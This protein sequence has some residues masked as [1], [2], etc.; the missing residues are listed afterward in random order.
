MKKMIFIAFVLALL[1]IPALVIAQPPVPP[2]DATVADLLAGNPKN[3]ITDIGDVYVWDDAGNIY[4][5]YDVTE[6]GWVL[7]S[8]HLHIQA[9]D[10]DGNPFNGNKPDPGDENPFPLVN[11]NPPPGQ[12]DFSDPHGPTTWYLYEIPIV[13][14][15]HHDWTG[16]FLFLVIHGVAQGWNC[17][18]ALLEAMLPDDAVLIVERAADETDAPEPDLAYF[19]EVIVSSLPSPTALDGIYLGWCVDFDSAISGGYPYVSGVYSSYGPI[20]A[21]LLEYPENLDLVNYLLNRDIVGQSSACGG[22]YTYGDVQQAIWDLLEGR[23][24]GLPPNFEWAYS[25]GPWEA[26]RVDELVADALANGEGFCGE[27]AGVIII[28]D[29]AAPED[30]R[31]AVLV[32]LCSPGDAETAWAG[33]TDGDDYSFEFPGKNWALYITY[34]GLLPD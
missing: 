17:D 6:A 15:P 5:F 13:D 30:V 31:Q 19:A 25:L 16:N 24:G 29:A 34:D 9:D 22:V 23:R 28:P 4:V 10:G 14:L 21:G 26:C 18:P 2:V 33:F 1:S 20:P 7:T 8:T 11:G 27:C 32:L 12:Y 3:G